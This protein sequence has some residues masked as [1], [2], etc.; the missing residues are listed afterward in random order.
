MVEGADK[1]IEAIQHV[2]A[3]GRSASLDDVAHAVMF[4][5][6]EDAGYLTGIDLPVDGGFSALGVYRQVW[7]RATGRA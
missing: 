3:L 7:R 2:T 4:L 1:F 6:G 5:A